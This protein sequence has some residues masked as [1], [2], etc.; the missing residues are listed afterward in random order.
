MLA[1]LKHLRNSSPQARQWLNS[2]PGIIENVKRDWEL[3]IGPPYQEQVSCSYVAPCIV[4]GK[5][6]AVLKIGLPH[7]EALHE[8]EG[9]QLLDGKPTVQL[10]NFDKAT[11]AMLLEQCFPGTHLKIESEETQDEII[12]HLLQEIWNTS[13]VGKP[14]RPLAEMVAQWNAETYESLDQFPDPELA[15]AGCKLKEKLVKSA[16]KQ[17]LLATDL[18]AGN[19]LRAQRCPWLVIDIKPYIG[20]PTYDLTQHLLNCKDRLSAKPTETIN[21]V[22]KLA[23]LDATRLRNWVF[24]RLASENAGKDQA[25]ALKLK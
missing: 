25:L 9:L 6:R 19:V 17:V 13:Y 14:F 10:L 2:L 16:T 4:K 8:I 21:R 5:E 7:E 15:K 11:N 12:C 1:F 22:A 18:H 24:A 20:D 3:E 23:G